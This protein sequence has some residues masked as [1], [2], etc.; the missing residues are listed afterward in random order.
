MVPFYAYDVLPLAQRLVSLAQGLA[1]P[2]AI[3]F[4]D[5][6]SPRPAWWESVWAYLSAS[7]LP[8]A[9]GVAAR[10]LGRA[11]IRNYLAQITASPYLLYLDADMWPDR[12]DFLARYLQWT[13]SGEVSVIYGGRS[14]E[15]VIMNGPDYELHRMH[16]ELREALPATVRRQAPAF[17][18]LS[19]NFIV[20]RDILQTFPLNESFKGWGWEDCEWA[21]RVADRHPLRHEDNPA[22]HLG[23]LTENQIL[24]KYEESVGNFQL[25]LNIRPDLVTPTSLFKVAR[26]LGKLHLHVPAGALWPASW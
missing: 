26:L 18:F 10:N 5:D 25:M 9:V 12:D 1:E 22:S 2:V 14:A 8:C 4:V 24:Q 21:V 11:R 3:V 19:C 15:K 20:H 7:T 23:L 6:G 16:T 17:T 13:A